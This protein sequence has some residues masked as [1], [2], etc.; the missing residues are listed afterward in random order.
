[1]A[2]EM[3]DAVTTAAR[4]A[5]SPKEV[6]RTLNKAKLYHVAVAGIAAC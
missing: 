1:V 2:L 6:I 3:P 4:I 5:Q